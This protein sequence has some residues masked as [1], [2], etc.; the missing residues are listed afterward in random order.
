M[1]ALVG[2]LVDAHDAETGRKRGGRG[3]LSVV[4]NLNQQMPS[5]VYID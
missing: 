2:V 3:Y 5:R 1:F 4:I